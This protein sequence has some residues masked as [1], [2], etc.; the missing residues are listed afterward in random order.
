MTEDNSPPQRKKLKIAVLV[1]NFVITGGA[2]RYAFQVSRRL[3]REH[4]VHVFCQT[5]DEALTAG[6]TIHRV[7]RPWRKPTFANQLFFSWY[8][9]RAVDDSFDIVYSH[10]RVTRFD[11]LSIHCHCYRGFL[12]RS[13]GWRKVLRWLGELTSPRG[14][15]YLWLE[16]RQYGDQPGR[17]LVADSRMVADDVFENYRLPAERIKVAYPGVDLEEIDRA[18]AHADRPALR[19]GYG[20][21]DSDCALLFV[22]TEFRRKGLDTL[23]KALARPATGDTRLLVAG[24]GD[25]PAYRQQAEQLGVAD[26]VTFLC[27]VAD[28]YPL[29]ILADVFVLPTLADP[30]PIAPLEAMTCGTAT[31][32]SA[33]PWCGTAEHVHNDEAVIL[34]DPRD[35][36][37]IA[38]AIGRLCNPEVR[39]EYARK[40]RELGRTLG[41]DH[42]TAIT[43]SAFDQILAARAERA[44]SGKRS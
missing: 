20:L 30:C 31:I 4:E 16:K 41:W 26:R 6:L 28:I 2:E 24:S 21:T 35:P 7:P 13:R 39:A 27:R 32:M 42:T 44:G 19:S 17:L 29:Y 36:E 38:A 18:L 11:V 8:C 34:K 33:T 15:A 1:R 14:L 9:R 43:Q 40:S 22:G 23:L 5:W 10:E 3:S 37:E 12:T 25:I